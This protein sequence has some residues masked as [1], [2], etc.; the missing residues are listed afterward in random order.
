M[1]VLEREQLPHPKKRQVKHLRWQFSSSAW[2][3]SWGKH[4]CQGGLSPAGSRR[5]LHGTV[6]VVFLVQENSSPTHWHSLHGYQVCWDVKVSAINSACLPPF[7]TKHL[8]ACRAQSAQPCFCSFKTLCMLGIL[9]PQ[10]WSTVVRQS[11]LPWIMHWMTRSMNHPI[12]GNLV[13]F[14]QTQL[15]N[16][17]SFLL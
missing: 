7:G 2:T 11:Y 4:T 9:L 12:A 8:S 13:C 1:L 15:L 6:S 3:S 10:H 14:K 16:P 17:N 5:L